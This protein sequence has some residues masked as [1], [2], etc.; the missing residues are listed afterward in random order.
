M[1][2]SQSSC[3]FNS[4]G[5]ERVAADLAVPQMAADGQSDGQHDRHRVPSILHC[6]RAPLGPLRPDRL[7]RPESGP[8]EAGDAGGHAGGGWGGRRCSVAAGE[9]LLQQVRC[10]FLVAISF[11]GCGSQLQRLLLQT[12]GPAGCGRA[13]ALGNVPGAPRT[14]RGHTGRSN[15]LRES[16]AE[17]N[18][19]KSSSRGAPM[20]LTSVQD[21]LGDQCRS[22][23]RLAVRAVFQPRGCCCDGR[24]PRWC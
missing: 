20:R 13:I 7:P 18:N 6:K 16:R 17:A 15:R 14:S 19:K 21:Q 9:G 2:H 22:F 1:H 4:R 3:R 12:S 10:C 5:A 11:A 23:H 24:R 8:T